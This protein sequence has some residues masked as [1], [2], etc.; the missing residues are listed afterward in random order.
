MSGTANPRGGDN[1]YMSPEGH[2]IVDVKFEGSFKL[3]GEE[4]AYQNILD[5][6]SSVNGLISHG[7]LLNMADAVI[8][9]S[10]V[11]EPK[12]VSLK[13]SHFMAVS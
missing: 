9:A 6:I 10:K 5:E 8:V 2:Y 1:P 7:L 3:F 13:R 11:T 12:I 4:Q